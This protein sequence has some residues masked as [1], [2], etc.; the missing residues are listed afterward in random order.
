MNL[1]ELRTRYLKALDKNR[2]QRQ[3]TALLVYHALLLRRQ[4]IAVRMYSI[5]ERLG[6]RAVSVQRISRFLPAGTGR[7]CDWARGL[8]LSASSRIFMEYLQ[9]KDIAANSMHRQGV[10][11]EL[12]ETLEGM[13][14][15]GCG[16]P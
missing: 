6:R 5:Q 8:R 9:N 16:N 7:R 1:A 13:H 4:A 12:L 11:N 14:A 3:A 10:H 15:A 2:N